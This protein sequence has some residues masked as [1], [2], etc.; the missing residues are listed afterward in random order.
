MS[1]L[2]LLRLNYIKTYQSFSVE[3]KMKPKQIE[4][5]INEI[6]PVLNKTREYTIFFLLNPHLTLLFPTNTQTL[7]RKISFCRVIEMGE[8]NLSEFNRSSLK[9]GF[10]KYWRFNLLSITFFLGLFELLL[11]GRM[12]Q[13]IGYQHFL[14]LKAIKIPHRVTR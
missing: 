1:H 9:R 11:R 7:S 6:V 10:F 12:F 2:Q 13:R 8:E 5:K 3:S 14:K 4:L